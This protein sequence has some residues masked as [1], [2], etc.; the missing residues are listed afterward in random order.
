MAARAGNAPSLRRC[1]YRFRALA[2][3]MRKVQLG[4]HA[5]RRSPSVVADERWYAMPVC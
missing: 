5:T 4:L 3:A 1:L 2:A